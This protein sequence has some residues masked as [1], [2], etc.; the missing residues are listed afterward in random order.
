MGCVFVNLGMK[1]LLILL[2]LPVFGYGQRSYGDINGDGAVNSI[3]LIH[4]AS[5]IVGVKGYDID[6]SNST[7]PL[8]IKTIYSERRAKLI[9]YTNQLEYSNFGYTI[10]TDG[11]NTI[12]AKGIVCSET[13]NPSL[14]NYYEIT[15]DGPGMGSRESVEINLLSNKTYYIR[16]YVTNASGTWYGDTYVL[17]T[18]E[19]K[20]FVDVDYS[21]DVSELN[22]GN[23][24][25]RLKSSNLCEL[26]S[27]SGT[28]DPISE[29][30]T[31]ILVE[32]SGD[33]N[34]PVN[35]DYFRYSNYFNASKSFFEQ[36][37][38]CD[39]NGFTY[40]FSLAIFGWDNDRWTNKFNPGDTMY[41]RIKTTQYSVVPLGSG[42][43]AW[44]WS[45]NSNGEWVDRKITVSEI[46]SAV[47]NKKD[48]D[49]DGVFDSEDGCP[50]TLPNETV[51][52][53]GC[54]ETQKERV[55]NLD[56]TDFNEYSSISSSKGLTSTQNGLKVNVYH[57]H[58]EANLVV[59]NNLVFTNY[60]DSSNEVVIEFENG[61]AN[62]IGLSLVSKPNTS[63]RVEIEYFDNNNDFIVR[64]N[65]GGFTDYD[66]N[67][68]QAAGQGILKIKKI[69]LDFE[70]NDWMIGKI[71]INNQI[72]L[73]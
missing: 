51:D 13:I 27:I 4:L 10:D 17:T 5:N 60:N 48:S 36:Q 54:S 31:D 43:Y 50:N 2:L 6:I 71:S 18:P 63:E 19:I 15:D 73:N 20:D 39:T 52:V 22:Y 25:F 32:F 23:P 59:D 46:F 40:E 16:S 41:W 12:T 64:S 21:F 37:N 68:Y 11:G 47:I 49:N 56:W 45:Q 29:L 26:S 65:I 66:Y 70:G 9:E 67:I 3:D 8:G 24:L 38:F 69:T 28:S 7:N 57:T 61:Y 62:V 34:F 44:A 1:K 35:G 55:Y 58:P 33:P 42:D 14:Y 72:L 30:W 53:N